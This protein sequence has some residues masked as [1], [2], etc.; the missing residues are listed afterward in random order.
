VI[1]LKN[2]FQDYFKGV[3]GKFSSGTEFTPRTDL[4]NLLNNIKPSKK[5]KIIQEP[6]KEEGIKGRPDF[7][8]EINGLTIGYIETKAIDIPLDDIIEKRLKRD[9]EQL[10]KYLKVIPNLI[11]T[12]YKEFILFRNGEPVDR[13]LL[14]YPVTDKKLNINNIPKVSKILNIFFSVTPERITT[15]KRLSKLLADRTRL[16]KEFLDEF[17]ENGTDNDFKLRL[18]GAGGLHDVIKDTLIEDMSLHDF[19][20][21]YVQTITY[22][23]FLAE[24]NSQNEITEENASKYIPKSMGILKELFKTI[25]IEDIPDS[26]DWIIE[27]IIDILNLVDHKKMNNNLS[28]SKI[29]QDEDPYVYFYENFLAAYDKKNRK[30]KGVYYTPIPVVKFIIESINYLIRQNFNNEG[31]K[32]E[33]V[34]ILDF[35]T[36]TGTFLLESFVKALENTDEGMKQGLI[37]ERLL[38]NFYGFEYLM[39]PYTI[40]HLKLSQYLKEEGYPLQDTERLKIYLTDTLDNSQHEGISYFQKITKE[41]RDANSIK[42]QEDILVLMG[43][44]PYNVESKNNK[45][46]IMKLS[47]TYKKGLNE[48]N[49]KPLNDDN[50][51]FIR[52]AH[53]KIEKHGKG[54]IGIISNNSYLDGLVHRVMRKELINTFDQIYILNL[55]GNKRKGEP[56]EN[57]FDIMA[58]V[59]IALFVKFP[60]PLDQKEVYYYSTLENKI[61]DRELKYGVLLANDISNLNWERINPVE[62]YYWFIK[63]NET[64]INEYNNGWVITD[65]F[66]KYQGGIK[67]Q[68]DPYYYT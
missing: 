68:R 28:F 19:I 43:N 45:K 24:I 33:N 26:I 41:G 22:G 27:E 7:K 46:W 55:H 35:A 25:D 30:A 11:L 40:A 67:T 17:L 21:A 16:F 56:D 65:I 9:S 1:L 42:L 50:I 29:Y 66:D 48:K 3:K 60:E 31:L 62:P 32:G 59:A 53:W 58:G 36:G 8:V 39:A 49:I 5:I 51:K 57:V 54:V 37:K 23:L 38:K 2:V 47:E 13:G 61:M 4:E 34:K 63:S 44:P 64:L 18:V 15:A 52:Y 20:D 10:E 6:R 12:N 14:F